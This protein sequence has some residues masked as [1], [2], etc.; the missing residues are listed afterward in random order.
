MDH[1]KKNGKIM[2][3]N[4]KNEISIPTFEDVVYAHKRIKKFIH[5]TP[6]LTSETLNKIAGCKLF[7]KCENFQKVGAFKARGALNAV[8]SLNQNDVKKGLA[9]HSSGN[10]AQALAYAGKIVGA[11]V[12]IIMPSNAPKP[13]VSAVRSYGANIIFCEPNQKAR[14]ETL[15]NY[16]EQTGAVF[17]HPYDNNF[18]IAG[19]GTA[20]KELLETQPNL[21]LI[22]A[23]IGGGGLISGTSIFTKVIAPTIK[24][25]GV[26]PAGADDAFRSIRDN[27]IYPSI[28]PKT[29]ADGLLTSLSERTF[30]IIKKN[31]DKII[32]VQDEFII[33]A[34][35]LLFERMK[36]VVEPSGA[37]PFA[38]VL[39]YPELFQNKNIGII[40]SGGNVDI[41]KL[42][43]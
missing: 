17:I 37:V 5:L 14:E 2:E 30:T 33:E 31:V 8:L 34:M 36:I 10:H 22:L 16:Q 35:K 18:V 41:S 43:F 38:A 3:W 29:I 13:K 7:F 15:R 40:I 24:I 39:E 32:T 4:Q 42:P 21:D 11:K 28:N 9:T 1:P 26:E 23:P 19:Q 20:V 27:T 12:T 25:I 6:V